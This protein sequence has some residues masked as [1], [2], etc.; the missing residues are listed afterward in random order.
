M[1]RRHSSPSQLIR[2]EEKK[3]VNSDLNRPSPLFIINST[4]K[5]EKFHLLLYE[6][7]GL[8]ILRA[9]NDRESSNKMPNMCKLTR[10][11]R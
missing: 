5:K 7:D 3:A 8:A 11:I 6:C 2:Q 1:E 4:R 9:N 10:L